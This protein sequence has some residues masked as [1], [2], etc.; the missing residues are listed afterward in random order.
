MNTIITPIQTDAMDPNRT[1]GR[2]LDRRHR[3]ARRVERSFLKRHSGL[4]A[5]T[6]YRIAS[7]I[8]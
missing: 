2:T 8:A 6:L 5:R 3:T 4:G 1:E 7:A